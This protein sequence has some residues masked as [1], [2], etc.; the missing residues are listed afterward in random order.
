MMARVSWTERVRFGLGLANVAASGSYAVVSPV[1]ARLA[2]LGALSRPI[3]GA[4]VFLGSTAV[5]V[6]F[7]AFCPQAWQDCLPLVKLT[8]LG[9]GAEPV[10]MPKPPSKDGDRAGT[11]TK[12]GTSKVRGERAT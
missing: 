8:F 11:S 6:I 9:W 5:L 4:G 7:R 10:A 2:G 1:P 12:R 3:C